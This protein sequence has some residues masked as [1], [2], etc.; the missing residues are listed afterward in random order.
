MQLGSSIAFDSKSC[1]WSDQE[2]TLFGMLNEP[3]AFIDV[4]D[5]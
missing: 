4:R 5:P 1:A 2:G 3:K